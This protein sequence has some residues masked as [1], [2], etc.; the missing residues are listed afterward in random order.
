[1]TGTPLLKRCFT[2]GSPL[3]GFPVKKGE[4][5]Q[6]KQAT[7]VGEASPTNVAPQERTFRSWEGILP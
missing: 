2:C 4:T 3:D 6:G 1:R 7:F 5:R